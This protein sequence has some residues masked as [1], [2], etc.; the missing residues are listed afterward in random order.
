MH[1]HAHRSVGSDGLRLMLP[2]LTYTISGILHVALVGAA[3]Y[4]LPESSAGCCGG[5]CCAV[6]TL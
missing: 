4:H 1:R 2:M 3:W 6:E 5:L